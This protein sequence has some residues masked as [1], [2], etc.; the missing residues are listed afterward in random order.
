M[1]NRPRNTIDWWNEFTPIDRESICD[2]FFLNKELAKNDF[3]D[4]PPWIRT[5]FYEQWNKKNSIIN[6]DKEWQF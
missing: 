4:L 1:K 3:F 5:M 2:Y 6:T